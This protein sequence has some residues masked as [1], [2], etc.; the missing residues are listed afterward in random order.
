MSAHA[1]ASRF[2]RA[3]T[4]EL[5]APSPE[6]LAHSQQLHQHLVD[7]IT[8]AGGWISFADFM[9]QTLYAPGLGY[10][11]AGARKFGQAGDFVTSPELGPLFA[12][13][14]ARQATQI[15]ALSAP[16]LLEAGAGS[17]QL[18]A[19]LLQA[20]EALN[21]LPAHYYILDV[22]PDLRERQFDTLARQVPHLLS[23]VSW[24]DQ[25]PAQFSGLVIGNEVLDA[26]PAH[27]VL[28]HDGEIFE[29]GVALDQHADSPSFCWSDRQTS[30]TLHQHATE[31]ARQC[32][33]GHPGLPPFLSEINLAAMAWA[34]SWGS[35][36][37]QGAL[38]LLDYGFS[39]REFYHPQRASG[40]LMCHYRHHAHPDPFYLPGLQDI[41][42]H[43]DFTSIIASAFPQGLEL[44]GYT[45]QAQFLFNC[46]LLEQLARLAPGSADYVRAT[47]AVNTLTSPAEMGELFKVIAIGKG[48]REPLLGFLRGDRSHTL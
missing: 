29:R 30:G 48:L 10:Y 45:G 7:T 25:L 41:T 5:P 31:I 22:S 16:N 24:L 8:Q 26:M 44:L 15:M 6:A 28:W 27:L 4:A 37:Q 13:T 39:R 35:I 46:G 36:L 32:G 2:R 34:A 43:V 23:R 17:G 47:S 9:A 12:Q 19:D 18:A 38:L 40:T 20:L 1:P 11:S 21:A 3:Q 42:T 33:L 14:L